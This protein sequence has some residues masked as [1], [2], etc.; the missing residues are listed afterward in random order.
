MNETIKEKAILEEKLSSIDV[1]SMESKSRVNSDI[2]ALKAQIA[3]NHDIIIRE[4]EAFIIENDRLTAT[5][6]ELEKQLSDI[7]AQ[8]DK[9]KVLWENQF[10][11][12]Q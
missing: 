10:V 7:E 3:E 8:Y 1:K 4:R 11:F 5:N 12:L 2:Q 9:D 6:Q